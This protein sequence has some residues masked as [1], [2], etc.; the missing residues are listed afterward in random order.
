MV[1]G[2]R[3]IQNWFDLA[4][5]GAK[6]GA[7]RRTERQDLDA[8]VDLVPAGAKVLD[9]GC[10]DGALLA[11]LVA[12]K[13]AAGR[14]VELSAD[15]VRACIARGLPVRHG[16]IEDGLADYSDASFDVVILSQTLAYLNDPVP[17]SREM[18]RVGR[19]AV[20]TF[21][22]A[23]HWQ[24]R[25]R[26]LGGGGAGTTL[27]SGEP[28]VRSITLDQFRAFAR[29][30]GA[31]IKQRVCLGRRGPVRWWPAWRARTVVYVLTRSGE[32]QQP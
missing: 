4:G 29:Q 13:Q 6:D 21:D 14:G 19:H 11:R 8:I 23:G 16:N 22:N 3:K 26:A 32:E 7:M 15:N 25:W 18:L 24:A 28:R 12:E 1:R 2:P 20:I 27:T 30:L 31:R 10:G 17:V 9:L 5:A